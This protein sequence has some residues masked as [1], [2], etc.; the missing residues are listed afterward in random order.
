M[1]KADIGGDWRIMSETPKGSEA[2]RKDR[3]SEAIGDVDVPKV[4]ANGFAIGVGNADMH[5]I[6]QLFGAP[7]AVVNMSYT[8]AKTLSD[9]LGKL[10]SEFETTVRR[11]MLTTDKI[12]AAYRERAKN[13]EGQKEDKEPVQ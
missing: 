2:S 12:D 11:E 5:I 4:Y 10:V 9:R 1:V 3:A 13:S 7:V 6:L 8:L